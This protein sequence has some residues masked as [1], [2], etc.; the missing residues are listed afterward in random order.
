[1]IT[2]P[3]FHLNCDYCSS[4]LCMKCSVQYTGWLASGLLSQP[5]HSSI[6][7]PRE[8]TNFASGGTWNA[9]E[10]KKTEKRSTKIG[11]SWNAL[12]RNRLHG[13]WISIE[14]LG[15]PIYAKTMER[16]SSRSNE[17]N[18]RAVLDI[19]KN[20]KHQGSGSCP[21]IEQSHKHNQKRRSMRGKWIF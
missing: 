13:K 18:I 9:I 1:M 11:G 15:S 17:F 7:I 3:N 8:S 4:L 12:I 10:T 14:M 21:S 19:P 6:F 16:K 20:K 2:E 5:V